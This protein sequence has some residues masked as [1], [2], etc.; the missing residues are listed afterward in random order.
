MPDNLRHL[1]QLAS[2]SSWHFSTLAELVGE[3]LDRLADRGGVHHRHQ[4][5]QLL[6]QHVEVQDLVA[7]VQLIE[8]HCGPNPLAC[9]AA[10]AT[11]VRPAAPGS[12]LLTGAGQAQLAALLVSE[13]DSTIEGWRGECECDLWRA[14]FDIHGLLGLLVSSK[15]QGPSELGHAS[16]ASVAGVFPL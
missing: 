2:Q 8:K 1:R 12:A 5:G 10:V 9:F 16:F 7:V 11:P 14:A 4:L 6:G 3:A 15:L 13:P